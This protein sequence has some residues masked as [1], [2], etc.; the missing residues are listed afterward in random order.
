MYRYLKKELLPELQSEK[1]KEIAINRR[2]TAI[3]LNHDIKKLVNIISDYSVYQIFEPLNFISICKPSVDVYRNCWER[4]IE[5]DNLEQEKSIYRRKVY[6]MLKNS[7]YDDGY[8]EDNIEYF[9][10]VLIS[11]YTNPKIIQDYLY[12]YNKEKGKKKIKTRH[13]DK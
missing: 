3:K 10:D 5:N 11:F 4:A 2:N 8:I 7:G 12:L 13:I 1:E 9:T 6:Y